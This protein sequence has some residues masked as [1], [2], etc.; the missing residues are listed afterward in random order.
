MYNTRSFQSRIRREPS[1]CH[2]WTGAVTT[3]G[4]GNMYLGYGHS[5]LAHRLAW[6]H[7]HGELASIQQITHTCG[8]RLCVNIDHLRLSAV[9]GNHRSGPRPEL[10][11]HGRDPQVRAQNLAFLR[12][13]AQA[14]FRG[15]AFELTFEDFQQLWQGHWH[16]R[17]RDRESTQLIRRDV[18]Q[19]WNLANCELTNRG[20]FLDRLL[21]P[22]QIQRRGTS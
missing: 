5:R 14:R 18:R 12:M 20:E 11:K 1:G 16:Q 2:I 9:P 6:E 21:K 3:H 8:H 10:W 22:Y 4:Y 13:R 19:P 15:E 17:G 7:H